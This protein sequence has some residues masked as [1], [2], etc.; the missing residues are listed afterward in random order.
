[1]REREKVEREGR[2]ERERKSGM[3]REG[4]RRGKG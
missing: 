4:W 3:G 2:D 1:M